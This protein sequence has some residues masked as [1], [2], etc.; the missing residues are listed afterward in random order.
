MPAAD[1]KILVLAGSVAWQGGEIAP[2]VSYLETMLGRGFRIKVLIGASAYLATDDVLF[3]QRLQQ[4]LPGRF[5]LVFA[6]TERQW[7]ECIG[8]ASLLVSGRFH[9]SIA[10][11]FLETPFIVAHSNTPKIAGLLEALDMPEALL[12]D[13]EPADRA[14][15]EMSEARLAASLG[16]R[17]NPEKRRALLEQ[18][19]NNFP[20]A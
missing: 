19:E 16:F 11:A 2:L 5:E 1:D 18:A 10:A 3:V 8:S 12:P 7:L 9:H 13:G 14:L 17:L 15:L 20:A 4:K 6:L